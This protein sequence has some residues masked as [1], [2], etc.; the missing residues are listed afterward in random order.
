MAATT[1]PPTNKKLLSQL[2]A[3]YPAIRFVV[4]DD[5][6]WSSAKNE[7]TLND[8]MTDGDLYVLHEL[9]HARLRH[10]NYVLDVQLLAQEREAWDEVRKMLAP[11]YGI[12]CN[13]DL[14]E[15]AL[16]T[17]REWLYARSL[18][19]ACN[20]SCLQTKTSTYTCMNC[21]C[22]WRPNDARQCALRRYKLT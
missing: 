21:R 4:G 20:A 6:R 3:D 19:P 2:K 22:S 16:D 11:G 1:M 13:Q 12:P 7:I 15:E 14:I 5:F 17:Y 18:C 9:A 10:T 8:R